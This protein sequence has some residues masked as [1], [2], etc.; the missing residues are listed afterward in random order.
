M[1]HSLKV[2]S[3]SLLS[4]LISSAKSWVPWLVHA[5]PALSFVDA[6]DHQTDYPALWNGLVSSPPGGQ[7]F[8][9]PPN[10]LPLSAFGPCTLPPL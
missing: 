6:P 1:S 8:D 9:S 7:V 5:A 10:P 4:N 2:S 3:G